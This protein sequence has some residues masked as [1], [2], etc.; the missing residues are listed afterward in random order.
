M[1]G[2]LAASISSNAHTMTCVPAS[3]CAWMS[4]YPLNLFARHARHPAAG[5]AGAKRDLY[6]AHGNLLSRRTQ[7][8]HRAPGRRAGRRP[9]PDDQVSPSENWATP[10]ETAQAQGFQGTLGS[11]LAVPA[12]GRQH[13]SRHRRSKGDGMP[14]GA[15]N[16]VQTRVFCNRGQACKDWAGRISGPVDPAGGR[17]S[18][19]VSFG[20]LRKG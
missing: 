6:G 4:I 1:P 17:R 3:V 12:R 5:F 16:S 11:W 9:S 14:R 8:H 10:S 13:P 2:R 20:M 19:P 7:Q 18:R 15:V